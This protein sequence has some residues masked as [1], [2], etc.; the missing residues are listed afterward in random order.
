MPLPSSRS[1]V[2][3]PA[4][5]R[6]SAAEAPGATRVTPDTH[7]ARAAAVASA[8]VSPMIEIVFISI[9]RSS[10]PAGVR[11]IA[12]G[13]E[14][15]NHPGALVDMHI[16]QH[17]RRLLHVPVLP[18]FFVHA[19]KEGNA[20]RPTELLRQLLAVRVARLDPLLEVVDGQHLR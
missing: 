5:A 7:P 17:L 9:P 1:S 18:H 12:V 13:V 20:G 4:E 2:G 19:W 3:A 15:L 10:A 8:P 11:G 16:A 6:T 14:P